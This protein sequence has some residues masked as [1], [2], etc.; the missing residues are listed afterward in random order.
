MNYISDIVFPPE[1]PSARQAIIRPVVG[2]CRGVDK[3]NDSFQ[4][5]KS[6]PTRTARPPSRIRRWSKTENGRRQYEPAFR[7][8]TRIIFLTRETSA[9]ASVVFRPRRTKFSVARPRINTKWVVDLLH[10]R[11]CSAVGWPVGRASLGGRVD[12]ET[13]PHPIPIA[14]KYRR[15]RSRTSCT[16]I[17]TPRSFIAVDKNR[18]TR[19]TSFCYLLAQRRRKVVYTSDKSTR[20]LYV[21]RFRILR[22]DSADIF[23]LFFPKFRS[24]SEFHRAPTRI[25]FS[26]CN[27]QYIPTPAEKSSIIYVLVANVA[28]NHRHNLSC[29]FNS[30]K[31]DRD[32]VIL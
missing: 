27:F 21:V 28:N 18:R 22:I 29:S 23:V 14:F 31:Y 15:R 10:R 7:N 9:V 16:Y 24:S 11:G 30:R 8:Q 1:H 32:T 6:S 26:R 2:K 12:C 3:T 19:G 5:K 17:L 13:A 20:Y 4:T 25:L